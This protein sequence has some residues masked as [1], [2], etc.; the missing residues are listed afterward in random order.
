MPS[1]HSSNYNPFWN[2]AA[3]TPVGDLMSGQGCMQRAAS[4]AYHSHQLAPQQLGQ[5][6]VGATA[7]H[8]QYHMGGVPGSQSPVSAY[9]GAQNGY[10]L[11][12]S[13]LGLPGGEFQYPMEFTPL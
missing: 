8:H 9:P 7:A 5:Q 4:M 10:Q 11:A 6:L 1:P 3:I 12:S 2:P 13:H